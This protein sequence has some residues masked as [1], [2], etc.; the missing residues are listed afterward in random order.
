MGPAAC[1]QLLGY[2]TRADGPQESEAGL[3]DVHP[4]R[5]NLWTTSSNALPVVFNN[6]S[7]LVTSDL[8]SVL[9]QWFPPGL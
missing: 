4:G 8:E 6:Y 2:S 7:T 1:A 9:R 3:S 5:A